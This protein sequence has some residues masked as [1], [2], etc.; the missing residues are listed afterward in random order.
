MHA[1]AKRGGLHSTLRASIVKQ[2]NAFEKNLRISRWLN[3]EAAVRL[4]A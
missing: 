3:F 4:V 1:K 2:K